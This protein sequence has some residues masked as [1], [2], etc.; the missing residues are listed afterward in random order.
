MNDAVLKP[1][2]EWAVLLAANPEHLAMADR[3]ALA[4]HLASCLACRS[5]Q[6][7]YALQDAFLQQQPA[8]APL[9][10]LPPKIVAA[11]AAED[12]Q[13]QRFPG[14]TPVIRVRGGA[15][16]RTG[17]GGATR[18]MWFRTLSA[19]AAV[20]VVG[21][22]VSA[23]V[24]SH[25]P[26]ANHPTGQ[27][28]STPGTATPTAEGAT[29]AATSGP[30]GAWVI[31]PGLA[32]LSSEPLI[33]PSHPNV[34]Y[35]AP[36]TRD[37]AT[38]PA[39]RRSEDGGATWH[40]L[41]VP[42]V[43]AQVFGMTLAVSPLDAQVLV[44]QVAYYASVNM[45]TTCPDQ[46]VAAGVLAARAGFSLCYLHY[47]SRDGGGHWQPLALPVSAADAVN[48]VLE[49]M[50][51]LTASGGLLLRAQGTRLYAFLGAPGGSHLMVSADGGQT[52]R[53]D[54][55]GI[56]AASRYLCNA[57]VMPAPDGAVIF[58]L[59]FTAP[60]GSGG[61]Q[62]LWRSD[63]AGATWQRAGPLPGPAVSSVQALVVSSQGSGAM[64]LIYL[65]IPTGLGGPGDLKVSSD[66][67]ATWL[68]A[69]DQIVIKS[70][71]T[72]VGPLGT[73]SDGS[74][75]A[76]LQVPH[77]GSAS[78]STILYRW[79]PGDTAWQHVTPQAAGS[80]VYVL[81]AGQPETVWMVTS[82]GAGSFTAQRVQP[83][84]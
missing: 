14:E 40:S 77:N 3:R 65:F 52:W 75:L 24:V 58:A 21:L 32:N 63:D 19:V 7:D 66:G 20:L 80:P 1:C 6:A 26:S 76:G 74:V 60:C 57:Q 33:A 36:F 4:E 16:V 81:V 22:L 10:G 15:G 37:Q 54:D 69:P 55:A 82:D 30:D 29:P 39:I 47:L 64:P 41:P 35:Q 73:L 28:T 67:G 72:F 42:V 12:G 70:V 83:N 43:D 11:W 44:L 23:L 51:N 62:E 5:A 31:P 61:T 84:S 18:L 38:P 71:Y 13:G 25:R 49:P 79:K 27:G 56:G 45:P 46:S 17:R 68:L 9:E 8:P 78:F 59:A 34:V 53:V 50:G 48:A 2:A